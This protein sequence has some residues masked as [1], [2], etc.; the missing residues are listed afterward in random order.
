MVYEDAT[1]SLGEEFDADVEVYV[2]DSDDL[3]GPGS[4]AGQAVPFRP[5]IHIE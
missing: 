5:T 2:E 1:D 4:K 3:V